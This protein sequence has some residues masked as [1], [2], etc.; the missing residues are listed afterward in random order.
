MKKILFL[1]IILVSLELKAQN[2]E[3][4]LK[5]HNRWA[6]DDSQVAPGNAGMFYSYTIYDVLDRDTV[7]GNVSFKTVSKYHK[8]SCAWNGQCPPATYKQTLLYLRQGINSIYQAPDSISKSETLWYKFTGT[9][10]KDTV[11]TRK[12]GERLVISKIDTIDF[13]GKK[14]RRFYTSLSSPSDI[15]SFYIDGVGF[16]GAGIEPER[17]FSFEYGSI[18]LTCIMQSEMTYRANFS[19]NYY[20]NLLSFSSVN[21]CFERKVLSLS[22]NSS[23]NIKSKLFYLNNGDI[24]FVVNNSEVSQLSV[25]NLNGIKIYS[26]KSDSEFLIQKQDFPNGIFLLE[27]I[28]NDKLIFK[29]KIVF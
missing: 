7:I 17:N 21:S 29:N 8:D 14:R 28:Q 27:I 2:L 18:Y 20:K 24:Q 26:S 5:T 9:K 1:F 25:Y 12:N 19:N 3:I 15:S 10:I 11:Y 13:N 4:L 22:I 6:Y 23:E 16:T